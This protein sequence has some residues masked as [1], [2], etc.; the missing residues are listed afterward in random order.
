LQ[1]YKKDTAH[2]YSL[3]D[4]FQTNSFCYGELGEEMRRRSW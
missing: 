1:I 3:T 2:L 4:E